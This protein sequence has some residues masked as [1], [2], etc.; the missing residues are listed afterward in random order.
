[1]SCCMS[2]QYVWFNDECTNMCY[3]WHFLPHVVCQIIMSDLMIN[4]QTCVTEITTY[5]MLYVRSIWHTQWLMYTHVLLI[6]L[7]LPWCMSDQYVRF[8]DKCTHICYWLHYLHY[9]LCQITMSEL[10]MNVHTHAFLI[11]PHISCCMA[12][13]YVRINDE[14]THMRYW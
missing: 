5:T 7:L 10:V 2:D 13:P 4:I 14:C 8:N 6:T 12:D 9:V 3:W 1:M 11:S